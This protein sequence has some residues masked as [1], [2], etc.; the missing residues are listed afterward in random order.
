[1][2]VSCVNVLGGRS[3][4]FSVQYSLSF[5]RYKP[6]AE[7]K[8]RVQLQDVFSLLCAVRTENWEIR[9]TAR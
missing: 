3:P 2:L 1:M 5:S 9:K 7:I 6:E 8:K 4:T